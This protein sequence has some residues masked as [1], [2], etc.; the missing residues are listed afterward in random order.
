VRPAALVVAVAL[1]A[2]LAE[3]GSGQVVF[4][5]DYQNRFFAFDSVDDAAARTVR[6]L[7]LTGNAIRFR[8]PGKPLPYGTILVSEERLAQ[9]DAAGVPLRDARGRF[10]ATD[11]VVSVWVQEKRKGWGAEYPPAQRTGEWEFAA[12][13]PDGSPKADA[14]IAE[15]R[16]CHRKQAR[17]D[18]TFRA[19]QWIQDLRD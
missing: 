19:Y 3:A 4:P 16:A 9:L 18:Y 5:K 1:A 2:G 6:I 17:K 12:F 13:L 11:R 15:C 10:L 8:E 14:K 7:Y